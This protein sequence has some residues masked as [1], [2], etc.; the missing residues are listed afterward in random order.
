MSGKNEV[1]FS[2]T[3]HDPAAHESAGELAEAGVQ[4]ERLA[5]QGDEQ[6][7]NA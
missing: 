1:T 7:G 4:L 6:S 3:S 2:E 5:E